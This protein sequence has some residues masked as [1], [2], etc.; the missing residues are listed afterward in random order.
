MDYNEYLQ[1][2]HWKRIKG[3]VLTFWRRRCCL[4]YATD[5]LDV[6]HRNYKRLGKELLNDCVVLCRECHE[7]FHNRLAVTRY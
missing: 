4:C 1:S 6:H 3:Y 2:D 7:V 5:N